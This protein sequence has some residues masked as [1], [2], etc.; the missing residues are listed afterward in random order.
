MACGGCQKRR[1]NQIKI[2]RTSTPVAKPRL[3]AKVVAKP[4]PKLVAVAK[5]STPLQRISQGSLLAG[6]RC[7]Q[8]KSVMKRVSRPDKGELLQYIKCGWIRKA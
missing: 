6:M 8:C 1:E 3:A 5:A 2:I 4:R 7:P